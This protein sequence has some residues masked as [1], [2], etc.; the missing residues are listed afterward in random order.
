[1]FVF[2]HA[3]HTMNVNDD[4][5]LFL[6]ETTARKIDLLNSIKAFDEKFNKETMNTYNLKF[7][8]YQTV[9]K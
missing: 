8:C 6:A 3:L 9:Y 5:H 4:I 7:Y 2:L 1:M